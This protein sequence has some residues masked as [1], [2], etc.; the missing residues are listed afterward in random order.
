MDYLLALSTS[1]NGQILNTQ[2]SLQKSFW[3]MQIFTPIWITT[4]NILIDN[5]RETFKQDNSCSRE[6][7]YNAY[8]PLFPN[9]KELE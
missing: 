4:L 2:N 3:N 5:S 7:Q 1:P 8:W 9:N 6:K